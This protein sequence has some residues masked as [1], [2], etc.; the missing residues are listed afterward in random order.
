MKKANQET[1]KSA[2]DIEDQSKVN[3]V[4]EIPN[5]RAPSMQRKFAPDQSLKPKLLSDSADLL[6]VKGFIKEFKNYI[7][8]GYGIGEE[9]S[10]GHYIQMRN[11]LEQSWIDR[12]DRKDATKQ[13][14]NGLCK[15]LHE[16]AER[17]YPKHQRRI[18]MMKM[19]KFQSES[20]SEFLRR[21]RKNLEVAEVSSMTAEEFG[22]HIFI[23]SSDQII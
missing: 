1:F 7:Q 2:K 3:D 11:I 4:I 12:L 8:S 21:I 18:N 5:S 17:K 16:E 14:L 22:I 9:V 15:L 20:R 6:E 13:N 10:A 19:K 23:E